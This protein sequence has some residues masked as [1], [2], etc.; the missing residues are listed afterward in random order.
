VGLRGYGN[1]P[2]AAEGLGAGEC[3][4]KRKSRCSL[5]VPGFDARGVNRE[6]VNAAA[7]VTILVLGPKKQKRPIKKQKSSEGGTRFPLR[8]DLSKRAVGK[9]NQTLFTPETRQQIEQSGG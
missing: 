9:C 5:T 6:K 2:F 3:D 4:Q 8:P 7:L 1:A